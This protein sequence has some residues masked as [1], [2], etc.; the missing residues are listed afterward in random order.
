MAV[1]EKE[2]TTWTEFKILRDCFDELVFQIWISAPKP[3]RS[4]LRKILGIKTNIHFPKRYAI[5]PGYV[6]SKTDGDRHYIP[7]QILADLYGLRPDEYI[8]WDDQRPE[9]Y[10]GRREE[11][12]VH[13][14]PRYDGNYKLEGR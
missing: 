9:T 10:L 11:D 13:L 12:Y 2:T 3:V 5:H 8:I 6:I 4:V 1:T 14:Y 7:A